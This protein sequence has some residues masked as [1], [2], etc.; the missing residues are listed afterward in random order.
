MVANPV[1]TQRQPGQL[2]V[3]A[4]QT[5]WSQVKQI[6]D[7]LGQTLQDLVQRVGG[8]QGSPLVVR[9]LFPNDINPATGGAYNS[10]FSNPNALTAATWSQQFSLQLPQNKAIG[11]YGYA[12]LSPSPLI[13]GIQFELGSAKTLAQINLDVLYA[14]TDETI[15]YFQPIAFPPV[16]TLVINMISESSVGAGAEQFVLLGLV[17]EPVGVTISPYET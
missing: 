1:S 17:A 5:S 4:S 14:D 15:A 11:F 12:S 8:N 16:S 6:R 10:R 3:A 9:D 7:A 2:L 13:D